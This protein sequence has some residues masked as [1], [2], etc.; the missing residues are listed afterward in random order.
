[1]E[2]GAVSYRGYSIRVVGASGRCSLT[3]FPLVSDLPALPDCP[4]VEVSRGVEAIAKAKRQI[5]QVLTS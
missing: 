3:I 5:D 4:L 1:M 2:I